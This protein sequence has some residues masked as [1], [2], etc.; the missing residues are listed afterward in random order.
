MWPH[1]RKFILLAT[2]VNNNNNNTMLKLTLHA[3]HVVTPGTSTHAFPTGFCVVL[4]NVVIVVVGVA[5][6]LTED[7]D[8]GR[9]LEESLLSMLL[10]V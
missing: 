7:I 2:T 9:L 1:H 4:V 3:P 6:G 8:V 10:H 5:A